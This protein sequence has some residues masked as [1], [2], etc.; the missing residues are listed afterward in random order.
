VNFEQGLVQEDYAD[1]RCDGKRHRN[2]HLEAKAQEVALDCGGH[3][4]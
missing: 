3:A 1:R 4:D 2:G